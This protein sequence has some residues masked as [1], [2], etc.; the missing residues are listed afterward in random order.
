MHGTKEKGGEKRAREWSREGKEDTNTHTTR[1]LSH[2]SLMLVGSGVPWELA[3]LGRYWETDADEMEVR[4]FPCPTHAK[5]NT[6]KWTGRKGGHCFS[7]LWTPVI[8]HKDRVTLCGAD[9]CVIG[10]LFKYF[11]SGNSIN[12][13][14]TLT[15]HMQWLWLLSVGQFP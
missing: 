3:A 13:G 4:G 7:L 10:K 6:A 14:L 2:A 11:Y 8:K 9:L 15:I 1:T 5:Y 12:N